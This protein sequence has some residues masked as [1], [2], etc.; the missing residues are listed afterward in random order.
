MVLVFSFSVGTIAFAQINA[1]STTT[2]YTDALNFTATVAAEPQFVGNGKLYFVM[3][4]GSQIYLLSQ[5]RGF[6]AYNSGEIPEYKTISRSTEIISIPNWNTRG[7]LGAA[8][9]VGYGADF[10]T[11]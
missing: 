4:H 7:Q 8:I 11:C 2:G 1:T 5:T 10:L 9:F 6:V 3:L